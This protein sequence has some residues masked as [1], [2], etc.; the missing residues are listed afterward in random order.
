MMTLSECDRLPAAFYRGVLTSFMN[1]PEKMPTIDTLED[2]RDAVTKGLYT[3]GAQRG[4]IVYN[5]FTVSSRPTFQID[6]RKCLLVIKKINPLKQIMAS[7]S[8]LFSSPSSWP[9]FAHKGPPAALFRQGFK[10]DW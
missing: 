9:S 2:L 3:W 7:P 4:T 10:I 8:S 1:F 5:M 6:E